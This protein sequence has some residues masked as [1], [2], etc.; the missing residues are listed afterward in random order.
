MLWTKQ[1][2]LS[3]LT[4]H[5]GF[6]KKCIARRTNQVHHQ[7][8]SLKQMS[9]LEVTSISKHVWGPGALKLKVSIEDSVTMIPH[10]CEILLKSFV[11]LFRAA[12]ILFRELAHL[13]C[14]CYAQP[15]N[16]CAV[17][18]MNLHILAL[19]RENREIRNSTI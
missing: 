19:Q 1:C 3:P 13:A 7:K 12:H 10:M 14:D 6:A 2:N 5:L 11:Y 16:S 17:N 8:Y 18:V 15:P 4:T 9:G